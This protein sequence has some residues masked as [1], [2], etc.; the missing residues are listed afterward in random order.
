M[1]A[2]DAA[3]AL[4]GSGVSA[5]NMPSASVPASLFEGGDAGL[6]DVLLAAKLIP[7]K[8]EAAVWRSRAVSWWTIAAWKALPSVCRS[9][10]SKRDTFT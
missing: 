3:R 7:S 10:R 2:Q 8:S 5:D 1:K 4:F 6:L 9:P